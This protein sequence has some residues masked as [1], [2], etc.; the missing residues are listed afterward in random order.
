[1]ITADGNEALRHLVSLLN[2]YGVAYMLVG[3]YSSNAYG[4]PRATKDADIVVETLNATFNLIATSLGDGYKT[5]SQLEFEL[6]TGTVRRRICCTQINFMIEIFQLSDDP[7]DQSRFER[8]VEVQSSVLGGS[9][10]LPTPE[11]VI[12]QKLRWNRPQDR[13]DAENVMIVQMENLDWDYIYRW[14]DLHGTTKTLTAI[15][16]DL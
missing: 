1:V 10:W 2:R 9:I 15:R 3:S 13:V 14:T 8:R 16:E 5:E 4:I 11:D 6:I 12:V 7:F